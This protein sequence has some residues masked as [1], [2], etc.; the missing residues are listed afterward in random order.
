MPLTFENAYSVNLSSNGTP[1]IGKPHTWSGNVTPLTSQS[2]SADT[3]I[4][5]SIGGGELARFEN[6]ESP[7]FLTCSG[8][9]DYSGKCD[10]YTLGKRPGVING[11]PS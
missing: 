6:L 10:W 9:T 1:Q 3:T 11:T 7:S 8:P 4:T 5:L 2:L